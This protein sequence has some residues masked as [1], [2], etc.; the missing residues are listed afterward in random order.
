VTPI[1][2]N[3]DAYLGGR[4]AIKRV[5]AWRPEMIPAGNPCIQ[6]GNFNAKRNRREGARGVL[7]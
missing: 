4:K 7:R 1:A 6:H 3:Y 5:N 2:E